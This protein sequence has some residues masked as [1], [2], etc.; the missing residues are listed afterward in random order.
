[1]RKLTETRE[2]LQVAREKT[3]TNAWQLLRTAVELFEQEQC[4]IACFLAMTA[5]EEAGKL[6]ILQLAQ[7]DVFKVLGIQSEQP[8]QPNTRQLNK[9]LR[10]HLEKALQAAAWSL[11]INAGADRR[12]GIH[13]ISKLHCTSGVILLARSGRW[14][15]IR[16]ACLYTDINLVSNSV[17]SPSGFITCELAYY[18][19]CMAFE[20]LA[21]QASSGFGN[22][23]ESSDLGTINFWQDFVADLNKLLEGEA[24]TVNIKALVEQASLIYGSSVDTRG[25]NTSMRFWQDRIDDLKRFMERWSGTIDLN[26]LDFLAN[27]EPLRKEAEKRESREVK[28]N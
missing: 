11:S 8:P 23:F 3:I 26:Q 12:H 27:P 5:I 25:M 17:I 16:N 22:S 28:K 6:F 19:I 21:E 2:I 9:F 13:P 1:M 18:F 7:G 10:N 20:V 4:A 14:M 24:S 15:D